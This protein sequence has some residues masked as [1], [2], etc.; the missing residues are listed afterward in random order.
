[1]AG[2]EAVQPRRRAVIG[3][4]ERRPLQSY[5]DKQEREDEC[6][7]GYDGKRGESTPGS[8]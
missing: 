5:Q 1:M 7:R 8:G 2:N 4:L 6:R 3:R